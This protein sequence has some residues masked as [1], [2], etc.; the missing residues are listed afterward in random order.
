MKWFASGSHKHY[1]WVAQQS[2]TGKV[3]RRLSWGHEPGRLVSAEPKAPPRAQRIP[4]GKNPIP[5][6][7][8]SSGVKDVFRGISLGIAVDRRSRAIAQ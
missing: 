7:S 2:E 8:E 5:R 4:G 3:V 1:T 6:G